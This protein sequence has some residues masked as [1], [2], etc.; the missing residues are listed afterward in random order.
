LV[1]YPLTELQ[2]LGAVWQGHVVSLAVLPLLHAALTQLLMF[3]PQ[4]KQSVCPFPLPC[5]LLVMNLTLVRPA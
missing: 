4:H 3:S 5:A 2:M 1:D